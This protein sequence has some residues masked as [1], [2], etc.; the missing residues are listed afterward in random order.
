[1]AFPV[2]HFGLHSITRCWLSHPPENPETFHL[3]DFLGLKSQNL[4]ETT[5]LQIIMVN[6]EL[7]L[8][9]NEWYVVKLSQRM[10]LLIYKE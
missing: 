10:M 8:I 2:N 6:G 5:S 3:P 7:D 1:M 9:V 4:F